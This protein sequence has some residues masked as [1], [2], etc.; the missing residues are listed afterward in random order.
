MLNQPAS[1]L[2]QYRLN[3]RLLQDA[4]PHEIL[5]RSQWLAAEEK[6]SL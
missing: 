1:G 5:N 6:R 4:Y 3:R 2:E